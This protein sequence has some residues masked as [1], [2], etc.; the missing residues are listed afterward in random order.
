VVARVNLLVMVEPLAG[1]RHIEVTKRRI[2][3][4]YA[5]CLY[6]LEWRCETTENGSPACLEGA[7]GVR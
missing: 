4:D 3:Q 7:L 1:W 6:C 5:C 2:K